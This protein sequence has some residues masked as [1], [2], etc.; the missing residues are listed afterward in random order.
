MIKVYHN[1][2]AAHASLC[3][4]KYNAIHCIPSHRCDNSRSANYVFQIS[5]HK[6]ISEHNL[7]K[8]YHLTACDFSIVAHFLQTR[9][10]TDFPKY[11]IIMCALIK[12]TFGTD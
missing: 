2:T 11:Y 12:Y 10:A 3:L 9:L 8:P 6:C 5:Q 7:T 1:C 4:I